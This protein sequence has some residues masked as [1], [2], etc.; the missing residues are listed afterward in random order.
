MLFYFSQLWCAKRNVAFYCNIRRHCVTVKLMMVISH[1]GN[2]KIKA[3]VC[4][5]GA[6]VPIMKAG[7]EIVSGI[8]VGPPSLPQRPISVEARK[9]IEDKLRKLRII[10]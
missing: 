8:K 3:F 6:W 10:N 9:R 7:M 5:S 2:A 1:G 4:L